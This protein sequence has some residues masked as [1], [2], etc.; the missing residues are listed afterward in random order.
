MNGPN[1]DASL[2]VCGPNGDASL[3]Y[4]S[5]ARAVVGA[6]GGGFFYW[7]KREKKGLM[8]NIWCTYER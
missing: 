2:V 8:R 6:G 5:K 3:A 1:G 4:G 7:S